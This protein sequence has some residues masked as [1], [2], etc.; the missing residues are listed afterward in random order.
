MKACHL[1]FTAA[2]AACAAVGCKGNGDASANTSTGPGAAPAGAIA[3][4]ANEKGFT[5]SS[6]E[7]KK[8]APATLVFK[9]TTDDTCATKVVF[10][11]LGI[12][13]DLP[14]NQPVSIDIPAAAARTLTFQCGMGMFKGKIVIS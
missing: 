12:T 2:L 14:L 7:L 6:V 13:K 8:G 3:I 5:P 11:E 9:R 10:P 4:E 1:L